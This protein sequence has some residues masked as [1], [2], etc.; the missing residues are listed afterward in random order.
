MWWKSRKKKAE[1][2]ERLRIGKLKYQELQLALDEKVLTYMHSDF[3]APDIWK[4]EFFESHPEASKTFFN[5]IYKARKENLYYTKYFIPFIKLNESERKWSEVI[6]KFKPQSNWCGTGWEDITPQEERESNREL[7]K[8]NKKNEREHRAWALQLQSEL[9]T[10]WETLDSYFF[11]LLDSVLKIKNETDSN[12]RL[13]ADLSFA[14]LI[15]DPELHIHIF[16]L[17]DSFEKFSE[18]LNDSTYS[19]LNDKIGQIYIS[20]IQEGKKGA[21]FERWSE[22]LK[23]ILNKSVIYEERIRKEISERAERYKIKL[24][25]RLEKDP[26]YR[27]KQIMRG[28]IYRAFKN[29]YDEYSVAYT[30]LGCSY[31]NFIDYITTH[32]KWRPDMTIENHGSK[33]WHLDHVKP[34]KLAK[35]LEFVIM[36]NYHVNLQPLFAWENLE[37]SA[38]YDKTENIGI[39]FFDELEAA[40]LEY[41]ERLYR[42]R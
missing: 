12:S 16:D 23:S 28:L 19:K 34:L 8:L 30:I 32:K 37:K 31:E 35:T 42:D 29:G 15:E 2:E 40:E 39:K 27:A 24:R 41:M 10:S 6:P 38:K 9:E 11:S 3:N 13:F 18:K 17:Y 7:R 36:Y 5:E 33:T 21:V 22:E 1:K 20:E 14:N 4:Q 26:L 25:E